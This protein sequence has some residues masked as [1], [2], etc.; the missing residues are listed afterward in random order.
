MLAQLLGIR[1]I[2]WAGQLIPR[3]LPPDILAAIT[4]VDVT[5]DARQ[6][7]GFQLTVALSKDNP[8]DYNVMLSGALNP[9]NRIVIAV[10]IGASLEV[11]IDGVIT[12]HQLSPSEQP[13]RST[14]TVTGKDVTQLLDLEEK[15]ASFPYQPD[16][17]IVGQL[18]L[19]YMQN[20]LLGPHL[21]VPTSDFPIDIFRRPQQHGTDLRYIQELAQRNGYVFYIEPV[22]FGVTRA[23][24]GPE[25]RLGL[26]QPALTLNMGAYTNLKSIGFT[27]DS[28]APVGAKG[29]FVEPITKTVI[30]IPPL[31]PLRVPL[32]PIPSMPQRTTLLSQSANEGPLEAFASA[33]A[34][35]TQAPEAVSG[36]G[37]IDTVRYGRVL[38]PRSLVGVRGVGFSY[39][40][41]YYVSRVSHSI[42]LDSYSQTFSLSRDG[43]GSMLPVLPT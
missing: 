21:L 39:D 11:L 29:S 31:P 5:N 4:K 14:L 28:L 35:S 8:F 23:Y 3:P 19:N 2:L 42:T 17:L 18:L 38:H 41:L 40:G 6:G 12:Q 13:G 24:F 1:M 30:P 33:L 15:E 9:P 10:L 25:N 22:T 27:N 43:T 36:Q 7:D 34:V 20:G 26:P 37:E 16:F 32:T